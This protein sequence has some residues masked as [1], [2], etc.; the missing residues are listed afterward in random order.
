MISVSTTHCVERI[1]SGGQTGADQ[2]GL[3]AA[4]DLGLATGGTMPHAFKTERGP[5][6]EL[7]EKFGL[8]ESRWSSYPPRSRQNVLDSDGTLIFGHDGSPG[9]RLTKK[10]CDQERRP[11]RVVCWDPENGFIGDWISEAGWRDYVLSWLVYHQ[12]KVLNVAGNRES[13]APGIF[14]ACRKFLVS[15]LAR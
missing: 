15:T 13:R 9:G 14:V 3:Y 4:L 11:F 12:I 7:A 8:V 5:H 2:A 10:L 1:I 6:P